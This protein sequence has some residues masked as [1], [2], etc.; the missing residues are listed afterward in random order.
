MSSR[1]SSAA[2]R[3]P[4]DDAAPVFAAL[5]DPTRLRL[6]SRLC[7]GG[8]MSITALAAGADVTRQ[9]VTKHLTVLE[10]AGLARGARL[11]RERVWEL[12]QRRL[13]EA[14]RCLDRISDQWDVA[15]DRLRALVETERPRVRRRRS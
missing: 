13:A 14:R 2:R 6:V 10:R 3:A 8:P 5:G 11:G 1:A 9:A 12:E 4:F 7:A 15:L